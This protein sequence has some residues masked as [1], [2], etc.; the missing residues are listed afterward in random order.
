[1]QI[2]QLF[3]GRGPELVV[4]S[5]VLLERLGEGGMGQVFKARHRLLGRVVALKIIRKEWLARPEVV[6]RFHREIQA[7]AQLSHP[8]IVL[9]YDADQVGDAH[10]FA[11][12]YVEGADLSK[13]VRQRGPLPAAEACDYVRQAAL[14][15]Q[16]AHERGMV[17]RDIKPGN[18]LLT[19]SGVVKVLDMGLARFR[20]AAVEESSGGALTQDGA[21]MGT[22]DYIAPEQAM[23]S[24]GVDI[25][26]DIYSLGCTLYHLLAGRPPF[27]DGSSLEKLLKHRLEEPVPVERLRP[28]VP[29]GVAA[30]V[31]RLMA[32]RPEDRYPTPAEAAA[33]LAGAPSAPPGSP[34][35]VGRRR[36]DVLPPPAPAASQASQDTAV[37]WASI[38][39]PS[40]TDFSLHD[41]PAGPAAKGRN[42]LFWLIG[43]AGVGGLGG[44]LLGLL[45]FAKALF[46]K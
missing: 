29:P 6:R 39:S 43:A 32:K 1:F 27:P 38:A 22:V 17:H 46:G 25:R 37:A 21:V 4:G 7:A 15:L 42:W 35:P 12:E 2:N 28:E 3:L 44:L 45:L 34:P 23:N 36:T 31:R 8:N 13:L 16:H 26:A 41:P 19:R 11:M 18:L 14:G 33:A 5:Y 24:R 10:F 30:V 9:A 40:S 20:S